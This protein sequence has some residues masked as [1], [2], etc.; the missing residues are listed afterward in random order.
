MMDFESVCS[1]VTYS[2]TKNPAQSQT[3]R[4]VSVNG[5]GLARGMWLAACMVAGNRPLTGSSQAEGS[6]QA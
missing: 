3:N 6:G 2:M 5:P 4:S 1:V